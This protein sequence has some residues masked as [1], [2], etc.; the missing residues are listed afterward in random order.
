MSV[1]VLAI[2]VAL[3]ACGADDAADGMIAPAGG[4]ETVTFTIVPTST[5]STTTPEPTTTT[6]PV[7]EWI[8]GAQPLPL[9]PDGLGEILPTPEPLRV[10]S[11]PTADLLPPPVDDRYR[12]T[13]EP[14]SDDVIGRMGRTWTDG[15]PVPLDDLRRVE[16][17]FWGF[18]GEHHTGELVVHR[19]VAEDI[20]W[21]FEQLHRARFPLEDVALVTTDDLDAAPTGDGNTTAAFVCRP[22][23]GGSTT[24]A[25]AS[26]LAIDV[27]P[28]TNPYVR[29]DVVI[30]E[31]ATAYLDRGW[32]RPGMI[33]P[34][35]V[36]VDAFAEVGWTWAGPWSEPD[37][38][39]FSA[40]GR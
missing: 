10:R 39:H 1:L 21:V 30:P 3:G 31:L 7:P 20:G 17:T 35:G 23:R 26:G 36:V 13:I 25:H 12:A 2:A 27:N 8:V 18:D 24:S 28:F 32:S 19:D 37:Y 11:L 9:R 22:V 14:L 16:L 29:G 5:S 15:R 33:Q 38:M 4:S 40:T 34:D 6:V